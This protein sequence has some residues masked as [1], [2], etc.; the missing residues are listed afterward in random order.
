MTVLI[1]AA[2]ADDEV[3]GAGATIARYVETGEAVSLLVLTDGVRARGGDTREN[4]HRREQECEAA[5][6]VLGIKAVEF[7]RYPDQGLE[8]VALHRLADAIAQQIT[9]HQPHLILTHGRHD[10]NQDHRRTCEAALIA[11][12]P[13][14]S[15]PVPRVLGF[16]VD[17]GPIFSAGLTH[18]FEVS[19]EQARKKQKALACYA[20][21][22]R[23]PPHPTSLA[24][25]LAMLS[26]C[27]TA[28][29]V[30]FAE[31]F[32]VLQS[33]DHLPATAEE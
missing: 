12:R 16:S 3:L 8:H 4:T 28:A 24:A 31:A 9:T 2:H 14:G 21:E 29:G 25:A 20:S 1:V 27:G 7:M 11:T 10:L 26:M 5:A 32:E 18:F 22:L 17:P 30:E 15:T 6:V 13:W 33:I 19:A 23:D